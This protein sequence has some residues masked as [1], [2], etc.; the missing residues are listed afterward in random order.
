MAAPAD[1]WK[2]V[3]SGR[4]KQ[5]RLAAAAVD[6]AFAERNARNDEIRAAYARERAK[7]DALP[8]DEATARQLEQARR[9]RRDARIAESIRIECEN[10][11]M[12]RAMNPVVHAPEEYR[13]PARTTLG[14]YL[15]VGADSTDDATVPEANAAAAAPVAEDF[16]P[17]SS[18]HS[19]SHTPR[20]TATVTTPSSGRPN[21]MR[22]DDFAGFTRLP[23]K[24]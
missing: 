24:G 18:S 14:A 2:R 15:P 7:Q 12:N 11:A 22:G 16:P 19:S 3:E 13:P 21:A 17:L 8:I 23:G 10:R 9:D 20:R 1:A 5:S 4:E 6:R